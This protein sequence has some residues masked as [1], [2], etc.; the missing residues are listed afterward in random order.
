MNLAI[1]FELELKGLTLANL[2]MTES[3]R[4]VVTL[5]FKFTSDKTREANKV[6]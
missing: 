1:G 2:V 6:H 5:E 4:A 3:S